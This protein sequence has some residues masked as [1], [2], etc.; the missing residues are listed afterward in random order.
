MVLAQRQLDDYQRD[1]FLVI[2]DFV[3]VEVCRA[4]ASRARQFV[5]DFDPAEHRS[6]FQTDE[7]TRT[8]D[9]WFLGS[10][11]E[12]RCFLEAE[13]V[14]DDGNL[15]GDKHGS[16]NKIGHALHDLDDTFDRFS[17][18]PDLAAVATDIGMSDPLLLQSMYIFKNPH[19]GGEVTSHQDATFL[20]T[21][22][23]TCTGFWFAIEDATIDN[24]C[25]WAIPGGHRTS[26]EK[27]FVRND[28]ANDAA[29]T[30]FEPLPTVVSADSRVD[31]RSAVPLVA[32]AG[33]MVVLHGL[34][35]HFSGPNRSPR[36][37][38]AYSLHVIDGVADYPS[39]NWLQRPADFPL[40]GF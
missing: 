21:D 11:G 37:R 25:L 31:E 10:G 18:N 40:R 7:Q 19:I 34:L 36:R 32:P 38:D 28:P 29:G 15:V 27:R 22:P 3:S 6:V 20:Y 33:T 23:I 13:A 9:A 26:L 39:D 17:R 35:P 14:D 16:V 5:D 8:S 30:S 4:L 12:I 1:G 24:G 2:P